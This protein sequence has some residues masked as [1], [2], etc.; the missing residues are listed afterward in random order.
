MPPPEP[1]IIGH[2]TLYLGDCLELLELLPALRGVDAVVTDPPYGIG[3][4][5]NGGGRG[6][7][8]GKTNL[9]PIHGDDRPFD[10]APWLAVAG[11]KPILLWCADHYKTRLPASGR[12]LCWDKSCGQGAADN[13]VDAE[14]AWTN[15]KNARCIYRHFWKGA[16]RAGEDA[17]SRSGR[18]HP[19]QKPVELMRWCL[20]VAR[21]G[22]G[23]TVLDPYMG[24]GSTG[25]ACVTSGRK[26]V[27]VEIDP[28][29]FAIACRRIEAA[30][31]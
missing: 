27:G 13:F 10:P 15:R 20:D 3:Y 25:V 19:S 24:G 4:V 9:R 26:F 16:M 31:R 12:F 1:V 14:F 18:V 21:V 28:D 23:K 11:D 29:Y 30:Q 8:S 6:L 7:V 2:A 22:L 17:P 5:H